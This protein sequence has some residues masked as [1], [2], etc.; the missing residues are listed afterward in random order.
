MQEQIK[1]DPIVENDHSSEEES[2]WK[3]FKKNWENT[4]TRKLILMNLFTFVS[5]YSYLGYNGMYNITPVAHQPECIIDKFQDWTLEIN[6]FMANNK[7]Y[8][9]AC[10]IIASLM[11]DSM[12][13]IMACRSI[14]RASGPRLTICIGL[15]YGFRA[16]L[17]SVFFMRIPEDY[18]WEYPGFFS[19]GVEYFPKNDF[20]Y[21][22]HIGV[23]M[24]CLLEFKEDKLKFM[25]TYAIVAICMNF[26]VL[27]VTRSHYSI[28]LFMGLIMGHYCY[29]VSGWIAEYI[30]KPKVKSQKYMPLNQ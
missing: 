16:W 2:I 18:I 20:F 25:T 28:D 21:S 9:N 3:I 27:L 26:F 7:I 1:S 23:A 29:L 22:G 10:M 12:S 15:F 24:I 17:Q 14:M 30:M 8:R 4:Y 19:I 13:F 6:H 11:M 5:V